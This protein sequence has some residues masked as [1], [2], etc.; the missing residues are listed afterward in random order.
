MF[1]QMIEFFSSNTFLSNLIIQIIKVIVI[2]LVGMITNKVI[3]HYISRYFKSKDTQQSKTIETVVLSTVKWL[4]F[5]T[6]FLS[7]ASVF[8]IDVKAILAIASVGSV[9]IGLGAQTLIKDVINGTFIL[10]EEQ[11]QVED[12]VTLNG[13]T[14]RVDAISLRTTTLRNVINNEMYIIPNSTI[15][16][17]ANKTKGFQKVNVSVKIKYDEDLDKIQKMVEDCLAPLKG[18]KRLLGEITVLVFA[19]TDEPLLDVTV[20]VPVENNMLYP[21]QN[22][23]S[24]YVMKLFYENDMEV[25]YPISHVYVK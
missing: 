8:H 24:D 16:L 10:L 22:E 9:A 2:I 7:V 15:S 23:I 13:V 11:F 18:D 3:H 6:V 25:Q 20:S 12:I 14:G 19:D 5:I 4:V 1:N 17:V 21:V